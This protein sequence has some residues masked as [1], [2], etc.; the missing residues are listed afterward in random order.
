M[1]TLLLIHSFSALLAFDTSI[2][3]NDCSHSVGSQLQT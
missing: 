3:I 1:T 2:D